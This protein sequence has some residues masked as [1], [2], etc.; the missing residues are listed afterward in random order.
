MTSGQDAIDS[1]IAVT[2][3]GG[4]T[5]LLE[6]GGL[7]LVTDPTF[8]PAG[9]EYPAKL[10][11]L[12]KTKEPAVDADTVK[13]IDA[14]L[15]SHDHHADNLDVRGR[16]IL[17]RAARVV[18]TVVGAERLGGS[19]IGLSPW[20]SVEIPC[21]DGRT[22]VVTATPARHGPA[23]G[24][25]GPVIGFAITF[26]DSPRRAIYVSGDTVWYEGVEEVARRFEVRVAFLFMGAARVIEVGPAHL[27]MTA[28]EGVQAARAFSNAVI[29]PLHFEGWKHLSEARDEIVRTFAASGLEGRLRW[30]LPGKKTRVGL[31]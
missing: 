14:V 19:A 28:A 22:L 9:S 21:D 27:T 2:Y 1:E 8:D 23:D 12:R 24:D 16:S 4:A 7:C 13:S 10:Y 3:V 11:V 25:R 5:A 31:T 15:L 29:V 17:G 20:E 26:A 30:P 6:V 18:T